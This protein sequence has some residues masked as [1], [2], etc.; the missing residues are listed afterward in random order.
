MQQ[1]TL[2]DAEHA[3]CVVAA[4]N[5]GLPIDA[6]M[7]DRILDAARASGSSAAEP[8]AGPRPR[9]GP[10]QLASCAAAFRVRSAACSSSPYSSPNAKPFSPGVVPARAPSVRRVPA[11]TTLSWCS[12]S[13]R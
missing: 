6:W 2:T 13:T 8:P 10:D 9:R 3:L 11:A 7:R 12:P 4:A 1:V 5:A